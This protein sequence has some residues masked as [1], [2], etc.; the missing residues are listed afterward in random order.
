MGGLGGFQTHVDQVG[1]KRSSLT[2]E[3]SYL[4]NPFLF[5]YYVSVRYPTMITRNSVMMPIPYDSGFTAMVH[6]F[7]W[8][9]VTM[10]CPYRRYSIQSLGRRQFGTA[11][12]KAH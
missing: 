2:S 10:R 12:A 4:R 1:F 11:F 5:S 6:L 7:A 9:V 8:W 3:V